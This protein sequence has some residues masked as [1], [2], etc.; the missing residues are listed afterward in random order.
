MDMMQAANVGDSAA[1]FARVPAKRKAAPEVQA[2]TEDHRLTNLSER[3]RLAGTW[4]L[5]D[6]K[7]PRKLAR[8]QQQ[9]QQQ[10]LL[11]SGKATLRV[12]GVAPVNDRPRCCADMGIRMKTNHNRLYGLNLSRCLGD[13]FLKNED[14]GLSAEPFVSPTLRFE[15][16]ERGVALIAS[17]GLWDVMEPPAAM[18]VM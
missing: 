16:G 12:S 3:Q 14:L 7:I 1:L 17:D 13:K 18:Q 15:P 8:E 4:L 11:Q 5:L 6:C 9:Q 10:Q 2:L